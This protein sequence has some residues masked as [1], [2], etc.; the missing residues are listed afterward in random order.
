LICIT[1]LTLIIPTYLTL[2]AIAFLVFGYDKRQ[3]KKDKWRTSEAKLLLL[4]LLGPFGAYAGMRFFHHK[5][6]HLKFI[7]V[8]IFMA[9]HI[10]LF[11]YIVTQTGVL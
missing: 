4:A 6:R 10:G 8:P 2:N 9:V 1:L 7:L 11:V 5:T 3:S